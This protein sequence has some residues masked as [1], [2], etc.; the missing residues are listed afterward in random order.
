[1]LTNVCDVL[2]DRLPTHQIINLN[3]IFRTEKLSS[4]YYD[5]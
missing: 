5:Q 3:K 2:S 1:M 4:T